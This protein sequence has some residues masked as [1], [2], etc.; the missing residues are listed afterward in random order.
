MIIIIM[1][2]FYYL[3]SSTLVGRPQT[4][5]KDTKVLITVVS[6]IRTVVAHQWVGYSPS[7]IRAQK[8]WRHRQQGRLTHDDGRDK[9]SPALAL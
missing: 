8:C 2:D 4:T 7:V 6:T 5:R 9:A 3:F 1:N